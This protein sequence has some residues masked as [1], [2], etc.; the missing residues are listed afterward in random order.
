MA[1][2]FT[3]VATNV[4]YLA[5]GK[6]GEVLRDYIAN[7]TVLGPPGDRVRRA[8]PGLLCF[9][10]FSWSHKPA[11]LVVSG[12]LQ[13][14][15]Q[16]CALRVNLDNGCHTRGRGMAQLWHSRAKGDSFYCIKQEALRSTWHVRDSM[17]FHAR[18]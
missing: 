17:R 13:I 10:W 18:P 3:L 5:R 16:A 8:M 1:R 7:V 11:Q 2:E 15:P 4:P 9:R 12:Q 6:Q 14:F